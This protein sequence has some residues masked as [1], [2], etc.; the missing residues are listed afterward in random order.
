MNLLNISAGKEIAREFF[1]TKL[2]SEDISATAVALLQNSDALQ[3]QKNEQ[4]AALASMGV[5]GPPAAQL[6]AEAIL[7]SLDDKSYRLSTGT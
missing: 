4:D 2:R 1:Q 3:A 7:K 6:A 5:G